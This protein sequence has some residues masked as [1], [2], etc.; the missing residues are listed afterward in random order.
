MKNS[1]G[2]PW[3]VLEYAKLLDKQ[4]ELPK[5]QSNTWLEFKAEVLVER[6]V[7]TLDCVNIGFNVILNHSGHAWRFTEGINKI[8]FLPKYVNNKWEIALISRA[9]STLVHV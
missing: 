7:G 8:K 6:R 9:A 4:V 2:L 1:K 5:N 3:N